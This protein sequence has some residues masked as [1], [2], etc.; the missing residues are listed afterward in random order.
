[1]IVPLSRASLLTAV[2]AL[3]FAMMVREH[4][5][6]PH[7]IYTGL[8]CLA[9]LAVALVHLRFEVF[10]LFE[11][12]STVALSFTTTAICQSRA[13]WNDY[14][15][16][17]H[18]RFQVIALGLWAIAWTC[19]AIRCG[20][21]AVY[22]RLIPARRMSVDQPLLPTLIV[23]LLLI[24]AAGCL[25]GIGAELGMIDVNLTLEMRGH[26]LAFGMP[27]WLAA[28]TV[29]LATLIWVRESV[30][31]LRL[32][33]V[34]AATAAIPLL[35]AGSFVDTVAIAS[36]L[37]WTFAFYSLIVLVTLAS[38]GPIQELRTVQE[39]TSRTGAN[40]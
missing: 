33:A 29:V 26:S 38:R 3:P 19:L 17:G 2:A 15:T 12:V 7:S 24:M 21:S 16:I 8:I 32:G 40:A 11:F 25:S 34:T 4:N 10:V 20:E 14:F 37:R 36:A 6:L 18:L 28:I 9:F 5:F 23:G 27:S 1:L 30:T 39:I 31:A 35:L 13:G 22:R